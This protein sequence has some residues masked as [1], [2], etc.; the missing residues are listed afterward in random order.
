MLVKKKKI[1]NQD[2]DKRNVQCVAFIWI[3]FE[4]KFWGFKTDRS[5]YTG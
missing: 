4:P 5:R 2:D 1:G 3:S